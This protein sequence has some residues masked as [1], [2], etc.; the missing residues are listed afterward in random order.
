MR[1]RPSRCR[2]GHREVAR[3]AVAPAVHAD[4]RPRSAA[5]G[6]RVQVVDPGDGARADPPRVRG[7]AERGQCR[8]RSAV[9]KK[10]AADSNGRLRLCFLP[11]YSPEL[12]PDEWVWKQVK[13]D[14]VG[15]ASIRSAQALKMKAPAALHRLQKL[16]H[17]I[18]V[19]S[20]AR[21]YTEVFSPAIHAQSKGA[22]GAAGQGC[23][24]SSGTSVTA[25]GHR[26]PD[27]RRSTLA[28]AVG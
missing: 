15:R 13:H 3:C 23:G 4:R 26:L 11:G 27:M 14:R 9:A 25:P 16:P 2:V 17:V 18:R 28:G 8:H 6:V 12:N 5:V 19:S 10:L 7:G 21:T 24:E 20:P 22:V 1:C